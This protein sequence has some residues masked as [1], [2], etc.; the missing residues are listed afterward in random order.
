[1]SEQ[2]R[3]ILA[4]IVFGGAALFLAFL[5]G[6][7]YGWRQARAERPVTNDVC[8][9]PC[10]PLEGGIHAVLTTIPEETTA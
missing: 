8:K 6:R 5:T 3:M 1:M 2:T 9:C 4:L 10:C 7:L